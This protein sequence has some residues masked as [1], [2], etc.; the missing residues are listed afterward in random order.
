MS[1]ATTIAGALAVALLAA[2]GGG[3]DGE[4]TA[5]AGAAPADEGGT[6]DAPGDEAT[7]D[8]TPAEGASNGGGPTDDPWCN[9][10]IAWAEEWQSVLEEASAGGS[11]DTTA[12][13]ELTSTVKDGA[14]SEIAPDV[15]IVMDTMISMVEL[16][17]GTSSGA[18]PTDLE[19]FAPAT[20]NVTD[21]VIERC[22]F[23]SDTPLLDLDV[24][25]PE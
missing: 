20:S 8:A 12:V 25:P 14:P 13:L 3:D 1:R 21:F 7:G 22:N 10:Y 5:S 17:N 4:T 2:C 11:A 9:S 16:M 6:P 18:E 24:V 19:E 15:T 23:E